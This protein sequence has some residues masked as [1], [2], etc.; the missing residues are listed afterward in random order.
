LF[1]PELLPVIF[2]Y[3]GGVPRLINTLCDTSLM[4]AFSTGQP[5]VT[6]TELKAAIEE[7]QWVEYAARTNRMRTGIA[8]PV[9]LPHP[10][11]ANEVLARIIVAHGGEHVEERPLR[12]GRLIIGRTADNDVQ[13]DS[14]YVSRHHCQITTTPEGSILE[15]LNS[16]N[17]VYV[18]SKRV[19]RHHLND[20]DV[21]VL[22]KHEIMYLDE[23]S[24]RMRGDS[25]EP[26]GDHPAMEEPVEESE[27]EEDDNE[28]RSG[29]A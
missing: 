28:E 23:R 4:I 5:M 11:S 27:P 22:G 26:T 20:G 17:G 21:V 1:D 19:R 8:A 9:P 25:Q 18:K 2:R 7:L 13:I 10:V 24:A 3:T 29:T 15:D 14:K 12:I 16:T 6:A